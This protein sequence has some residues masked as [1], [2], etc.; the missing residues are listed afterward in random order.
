[1]NLFQV[2]AHEI[3]HSL[4]L[5]HSD[6]RNALMAPFYRGYIPNFKLSRDDVAAVQELYGKIN[7]SKDSCHFVLLR[8]AIIDS[9]V[10]T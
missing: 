10:D 4:G 8:K 1:M 6:V 9:Q 7:L 5:A 3:G 2:A